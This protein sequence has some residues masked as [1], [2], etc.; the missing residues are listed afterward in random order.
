M[1]IQK[2]AVEEALERI[3]RVLTGNVPADDIPFGLMGETRAWNKSLSE[4]AEL[5][6]G[7]LPG[8]TFTLPDGSLFSVNVVT[9]N[10]ATYTVTS[11]DGILHVTRSDAGV[12]AITIPTSL[13]SSG[14]EFTVKDAAINSSNFN[15]TVD[16]EG[17]EKIDEE[18]IQVLNISGMS[19]SLYSDGSNWFIK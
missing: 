14:K 12:C 5:M 15:I 10:T 4:L 7:S 16:T 11:T 2:Y 8:E 17:S 6:Q 3:L 1:T 19:L 18:D 9:V 13:L